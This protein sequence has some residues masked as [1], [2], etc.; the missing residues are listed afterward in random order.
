M[1]ELAPNGRVRAVVEDGDDADDSDAGVPLP[2]GRRPAK[3]LRPD[4]GAS[5]F[6]DDPRLE[7]EHANAKSV[8]RGVAQEFICPIDQTPVY[9]AVLAAD[10]CVYERRSIE[11][12]FDCAGSKNPGTGLF[13][14]PSTGA[15]LT[16]TTLVASPAIKNAAQRLVE[17]GTLDLE[18]VE[19]WEQKRKEYSGFAR[20]VARARSGDLDA[21]YSMGIHHSAM[22]F[23]KK[24]TA[25]AR[26]REKAA[27]T[28]WFQ[29]GAE[30]KG[31]KSMACYG[32]ALL[33]GTGVAK[34]TVM[35]VYLLMR[36]AHRCSDLACFSLG[37]AAAGVKEH[38][39]DGVETDLHDARIFLEMLFA[40]HEGEEAF[41][42]RLPIRSKPKAPTH[43]HLKPELLD[44]ARR[45]LD[46]LPPLKTA[47]SQAAASQPAV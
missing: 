25:E 34:N 41:P 30:A 32:R 31:V 9:D 3:R 28:S 26:N 4:E 46:R 8:I 24:Y 5:Q 44:A 39:I 40:I 47:A 43:K 36:A 13:R 15:P 16:S 17:S 2:N 11:E 45:V 14:S 10:G 12:W 20:Q 27:A 18:M 29:K 35:G 22:G 37:M 1:N 38:A 33:Y 19:A 42:N 7:R 6:A 23:D 21:I